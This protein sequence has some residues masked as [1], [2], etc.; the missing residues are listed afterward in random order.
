MYTLILCT[1][2]DSQQKHKAILQELYGNSVDR[3]A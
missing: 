1:Y 3:V 2:A